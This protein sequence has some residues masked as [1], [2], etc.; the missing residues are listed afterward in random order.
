M[1]N[2]LN[3]LFTKLPIKYDMSLLK[4]MT[5]VSDFCAISWSA[6]G[7]FRMHSS[8]PQLGVYC[9]NSD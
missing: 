3:Q 6:I 4:K 7:S 2:Y 5:T 9:T 1:K 8:G